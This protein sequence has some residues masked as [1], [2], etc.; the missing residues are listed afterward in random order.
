MP[1][2]M[3]AFYL[4]YLATTRMSS[5]LASIAKLR[6]TRYTRKNLASGRWTWIRRVISSL[7]CKR[8]VSPSCFALPMLT[9]LRALDARIVPT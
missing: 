8:T 4:H 1:N 9:S 7:S 3:S 6:W 5:P 2:R